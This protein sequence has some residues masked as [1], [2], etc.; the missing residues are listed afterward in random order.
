MHLRLR[1]ET[2]GYPTEHELWAVRTE[3]TVEVEVD[4]QTYDAQV[5]RDGDR[6]IVT[7]DGRSIPVEIPADDVAQVAGHTLSFDL[8]A[9][10]PGGA[11][12]EHDTLIQGAGAV[13]PPMPG[14]ISSLE[15]EEGDEVEQGQTVAVLEAMKMQSSIEAP[16]AGTVLRIHVEPGQAVEARDVIL[17]IGDPDDEPA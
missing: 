15:V 6:L 8:L 13:Q 12:G 11:P 10:E 2:D 17:E 14:K 7:I 4:G 16:R 5:Q 3:Q 9:F 1:L